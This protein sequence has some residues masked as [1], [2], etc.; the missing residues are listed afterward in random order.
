MPT[1]LFEI[2]LI[3]I[4]GSAASLTDYAGSVLLTS[5]LHPNAG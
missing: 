4:D 3:R 2:P 5:T 1:P